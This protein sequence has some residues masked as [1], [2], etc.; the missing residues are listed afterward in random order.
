[1]KWFRSRWQN[2]SRSEKQYLIILGLLAVSIRL[3]YALTVDLIPMDT[4]GIDMDAVEYDHL[5]WSVAQGKGMVD[6]NSDP[7]SY[8]FPGYVYF[9]ACIYFI[10]GHHHIAALLFQVVLGAFTPLLIY[11]TARYIFDERTSRIAGITAALYPVFINY[12]A[13]LMT[14]NLFLLLLNVLILMTVSL[15]RSASW[16]KLI[17]LGFVIGLLGLTRG[18]GLPFMGL[19]PLYIFFRL[20]DDVWK[21]FTRAIV[22]VL[23]AVITMVPWTIRNYV[24]YDEIM[25]PS[26]EGGGILWLAF[27]RVSF[28]TYYND[29]E[30]FQYVERVGRKNAESEEFYRLLLENNIFGLTGIQKIFSDYF[31]D[32]PLP[33]SEPEAAKRLGRKALD[34]LKEMPEVWVIKSVTQVFRFWHVLDERAR[35]VYGYAFILPF[36]AAGFWLTRRRIPDLMPLYLFPLVLYGISILFFADARFRM[37]FEGVF[38]IVA[39]FA[40]GKFIDLFKR[41]Y[42]AYG[43]L[44]TLF[45][46]N[47]Y[48]RLHSLEVRL[49]IRSLAGALGLQV[50]EIE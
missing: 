8:R 47:Y 31:P 29:T 15:G 2:L 1:M 35:Y 25:L 18:V 36:F 37:P 26:S 28:K 43:I 41:P 46:C 44:V 13:Y 39:A 30:A 20:K 21:R 32:E 5:G 16:R 17:F 3:I 10:F 4:T 12:V 6:A 33:L 48:L 9:L 7:T 11:L 34:L 45:F 22:V 38:L 14:E 42:W 27:N 19:I 23:A 24:T 50:S 40:I 49:A